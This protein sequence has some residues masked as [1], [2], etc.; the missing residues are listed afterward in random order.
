MKLRGPGRLAARIALGALVAATT[1]VPVRAADDAVAAARAAL[2]KAAAP[3]RAWNGP[4]SGPKAQAGK[5]V[6]YVST[7]QQ[8]GGALGVGNGVVEAAK[9][10]GWRSQVID[11][12]GTVSGQAAAI[13]GAIALKPD[14]IVLGGIDAVGQKTA[15]DRA[16]RLGIKVVGWH[17]GPKPGP[18]DDPELFTNVETR[19][20]DTAATTADYVI[21]TSGG[22]ANAVILTDSQYAIAVLK[23][24]TMQ[25]LIEGCKTCSILDYVDSP[26]AESST[27]MPKVTLSLKGR[28]G[29]KLTWILAINDRYFD[30]AAP[31]LRSAGV[32][33]GGPPQF[34]SAGDGSSSAYNRI[35]TGTYQVATIPEPLN[36]HG[37]QIVDELNRALAG[38]PPSGYVTAAHLVTKQN[39]GTD[40]GPQNIFDPDNGYR[41]KY[42]AIW[43]KMSAAR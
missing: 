27:R 8:N 11:G 30:F 28:F 14:G 31:A 3:V 19:A 41:D 15:V 21:A 16:V 39:I 20:E 1:A 12:Q 7:D 38:Q 9:T 5:F 4:G 22:K 23:A 37:W 18:I 24:K 17:A 32:G 6:V 35:R 13:N 36:L 34:V 33:P 25:K 26:I 29:P 10:I 40:G 43:G 42:K 2:A